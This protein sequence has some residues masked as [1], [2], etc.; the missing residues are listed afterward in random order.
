MPQFQTPAAVRRFDAAV[1]KRGFTVKSVKVDPRRLRP[2]QRYVSAKRA[3]QIDPLKTK[4]RIIVSYDG[5]IVDGH[6]RWAA[7]DLRMRNGVLP[8]TFRIAAREYGVEAERLLQIARAVSSTR[9]G[10]LH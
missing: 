2:M 9:H 10:D 5:G 7:A 8:K 4:G 3:A 1:R 6:H